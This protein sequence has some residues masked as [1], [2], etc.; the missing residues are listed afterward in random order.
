MAVP[1]R[2]RD[3]A[4]ALARH[5]GAED[6]LVFVRDESVGRALPAL[7]FP[8]TLPGGRNWR[9]LVERAVEDGAAEGEV[10]TPDGKAR[11]A[12]AVGTGDGTVLVHLGAKPRETDAG[13][14]RMLL[15]VLGVLFRIEW[16]VRRAESESNVAR[17]AAAQAS[18][19]AA[20]LDSARSELRR[21]LSIAETATRARDEFLAT[22]SHEL[23]TPLTSILGW[24]ELL[25][26][27]QDREAI[28]EGLATIARN[29][30]AQN[31]LIEDLLEF[32]RINAG[33]LRLNVA[34]IDLV[35]V[36]RAAVDV[37]RP[38]ANAKGVVLDVVLDPN[39]GSISGDADRLQQIVWNL[40]SNAVKF[41]PR[42]GKVQVRLS[43]IN[44]HVEMRVSDTGEGID[45]KFLPHVFDRFSQADASSTRT[46]SGLGLGL[47]IVRHLVELHGGTIDASSAGLGQGSTFAVRLPV[48][49]ARYQKATDR[50]AS[51]PTRESAPAEEPGEQ[52]SVDL[53]GISVL[54]VEDNADART[55]V[56]RILERRGAAVEAV[57]NVSSALQ[58][59]AAKEPDVIVSDIEMPGE[60]GY[61]LMLTIRGMKTSASRVPAIAL[62]A[63]AR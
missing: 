56:A 1:D 58:A 33:K 30:R 8:Q 61:S 12:W 55:L 13:V 17:Q 43:R 10:V 39:A 5:T 26:D 27:E 7:G 20:K 48:L 16:I 14:L 22:L 41:T 31:R 23:R 2:R 40:M 28:A 50:P 62:T 18:D 21:A 63:Y 32:S 46:H 15:P 19:L 38:G 3:A 35:D 52:T 6:L 11:R 44:S 42:G 47:S 45:A 51:V 53:T 49:I 24:T 37:V 29:A 54:V 25:R 36:M 57:E 9:T 60:D 4:R 59:V 34:P